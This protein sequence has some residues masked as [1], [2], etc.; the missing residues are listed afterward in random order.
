MQQDRDHVRAAQRL[1]AGRNTLRQMPEGL[2]VRRR[3]RRN[4]HVLAM[5]RERVLT[6]GPPRTRR[7]SREP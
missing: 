2:P 7:P 6:L 5:M 1:A 4:S 3:P